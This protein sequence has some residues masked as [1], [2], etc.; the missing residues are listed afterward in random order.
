MHA[1]LASPIAARAGALL[2]A[3]ERR[4]A[5]VAA[6][7]IPARV[8]VAGDARL[9]ATAR[10]R[11]VGVR[12]R[13]ADRA[14]VVPR[15]SA[16]AA[17]DVG[18]NSPRDEKL[19]VIAIARAMCFYLVTFTLALPLFAA[20][21]AMFPFTYLTD[22]YRRYALSFVNDIWAV[23]STGLF[24]KVEVIGKENLPPADAGAVYVA[25]HASYLDIYSLFH[26]RRP[27]KFISKV[28]NFIIPIIGWSMYMT[29][30]IALKRTDRKSQMKTLKDCRELLQKDCPVLF[31]PEGTRSPDGNMGDFKKGAFSVAAKEKAL[32]VPVTLVGTADRMANGKEWMLR[33]GGI[34]V[35]VHPPIKCED[36]QACCDESYR[37]IKEALVQHS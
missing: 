28:S 34:K 15:A 7:A 25:N 6:A 33:A 35:I 31:F 17:A 11:A 32:V 19:S 37:V 22:K 16:S 3:R 23:I 1:I 8:S 27:F 4:A 21:C 24:F 9:R 2:P 12:A 13:V 30:H 26:L 36:A 14:S 10:L 20:M 29:G 18:A 5:P